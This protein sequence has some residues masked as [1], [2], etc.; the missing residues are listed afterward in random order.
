[1]KR[2]LL[3]LAMFF[4]GIM[5][6]AQAPE[7]L[8]PDHAM[9]RIDVK[10]R[11]LLLP[12]QESEDN[13]NVKVIVSGEQKQAFNIRLA[14]TKV[15]YFV[16]LDISRFGSGSLVLDFVLR[17]A[18]RTA[19]DVRKMVCWWEIRQDERFDTTNRE[20]F[21]PAYHHTPEYG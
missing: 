7:I 21:R 19:E 16:P 13:S 17:K 6:S 1:M 10:D 15:D 14:A 5:A 20:R 12:V 8:S 11:Y 18:G 2:S 9:L 3:F 4:L